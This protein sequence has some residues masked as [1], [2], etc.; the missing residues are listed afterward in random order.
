MPT[1]TSEL[2]KKP[3][4]QICKQNWLNRF[5]SVSRMARLSILWHLIT[6]WQFPKS[7]QASQLEQSSIN[8]RFWHYSF[9]YNTICQWSCSNIESWFGAMIISSLLSYRST[10]SGL[11]Q[12]LFSRLSQIFLWSRLLWF[13]SKFIKLL[14]SWLLTSVGDEDHELADW[15]WNR[16]LE[17]KVLKTCGL[18]S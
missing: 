11:T 14:R 5:F 13:N 1:G 2:R 12:P 10:K 8:H 6:R 16:R 7:I 4:P 18:L 9:W 15:K 17:Q 3:S